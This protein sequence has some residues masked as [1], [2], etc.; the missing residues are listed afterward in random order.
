MTAVD[1]CSEALQ[2]ADR[3][4]RCAGGDETA[5]EMMLERWRDGSGIS[6]AVPRTGR[7]LWGR[8]IEAADPFGARLP[9]I[10]TGG[11]EMARKENWKVSG[12]TLCAEAAMCRSLGAKAKL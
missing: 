9:T 4:G 8:R 10:D 1:A 3:D 5:A 2:L 11:R 12:R 7:R 6:G